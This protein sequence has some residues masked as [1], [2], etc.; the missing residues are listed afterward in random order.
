L[1][2]ATFHL[3]STA[4]IWPA[5]D[6]CLFVPVEPSGTTPKFDCAFASGEV[7]KVKYGG[8]PEP[9]AEVAATRLLH[10]LGYGADDVTFTPR[11]RCY[12]CPRHPF[13][14]MHITTA[15]HALRLP[16][17]TPPADSYTDFTWVSV[18]RNLELPAVETE[19]EKGWA[20]WELR[21][22]EAGR[23][24]LDAFRLLAVF[25]A[26]WDNKAENQR[27]V[28]ID[29]AC[30]QTLAMM[31]DVG[32]TFG[33]NKVNLERWRAEPIW[34]DRLRCRVSMANLPFNGATF[35]DA[36][37]SEGGRALL[38]SELA[39]LTDDDVRRIFSD[40]RFP[41]FYPGTDNERDLAAWTAAFNH[42]VAQI[43]SNRC[44]EP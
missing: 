40:A 30:S 39:R 24:E 17:P 26:H 6:S 27:L 32:A 18:E 19:T 10:A 4:P 33:P 11:L 38:A 12:G 7:M 20:W 35:P 37:I 9:H 21:R 44:R 22:S 14:A 1:R 15:M 31:Q 5:L 34:A 29:A 13:V 2:Q 8:T 3:G 42:R 43:A 25:L 36:T 23:E 41:E 16:A 28:C